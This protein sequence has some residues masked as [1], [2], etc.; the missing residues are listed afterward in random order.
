MKTAKKIIAV[1]MILSM[2]LA[3]GQGMES[4]KAQAESYQSATTINLNG[5][6]TGDKYITQSNQEHWYKMYVPSDGKVEMKVMEY[7]E[8]M[9]V[10]LRL[11][12]QRIRWQCN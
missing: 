5:G 11:P 9:A 3:L 8:Y 1:I 10:Y 6:W 12:H 2:T 4:K 7:M